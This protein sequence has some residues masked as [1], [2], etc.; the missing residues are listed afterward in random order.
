L[1]LLQPQQQA[2]AR[3]SSVVAPYR[4]RR[5]RHQVVGGEREEVDVPPGVADDVVNEFLAVVLKLAASYCLEEE[6]CGG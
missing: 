4:D 5:R 3:P 2:Y 1:L 6:E